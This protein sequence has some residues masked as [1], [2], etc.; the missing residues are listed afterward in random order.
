MSQN[1]KGGF[2]PPPLSKLAWK[3]T[4][5]NALVSIK[6][7]KCNKCGAEKT[8]EGMISNGTIDK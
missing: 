4:S 1:T 7:D 8:A 6:L 2:R 3:C 5:C